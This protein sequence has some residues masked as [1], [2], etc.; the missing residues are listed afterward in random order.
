LGETTF[1][2]G[3]SVEEWKNGRVEDWKNG[4]LEEWRNGRVEEWVVCEIINNLMV[5]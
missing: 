5:W 3:A 4:R 2:R 1:A